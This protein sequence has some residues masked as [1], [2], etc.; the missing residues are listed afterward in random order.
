MIF[1][2]STIEDAAGRALMRELQS[3]HFYTPQGEPRYERDDGKPVT[4]REARKENLFPSIT[5]IFNVLGNRPL[6]IYR[7]KQLLA[8]SFNLRPRNGEL[9]DD[10][11][12]RV[13]AKARED[14]KGAAD[15][16][17]E[18][19]AGIEAIL[20]RERWDTDNPRLV[21]ANEW[22]EENVELVHWQEQILVDES[23]GL[24]GRCDAFL[25]LK[26]IGNA[27]VDW[28]TRRFK[29]LKSGWKCNWY[30]KDSRQIAFY[31]ACVERGLEA[32]GLGGEVAAINVAINTK[33]V[34]PVEVKEWTTAERAN[35]LER[36][37]EIN[38]I[39]Q[40]ENN[41]KPPGGDGH[42]YL[43]LPMPG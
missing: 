37:C 11:F 34:S 4:L 35:A 12:A 8:A 18:T 40:D 23:M 5:H 17:T 14:A 15:V 36:V 19:H 1:E 29:E 42:Y 25:N 28:K 39:W 22:I 41:Y 43:G 20:K 7:E 9:D 16:G 3:A 30:K 21:I 31:A 32:V 33:A 27:V 6:T 26:G 10:Y 38:S 13:L 24:A 2:N